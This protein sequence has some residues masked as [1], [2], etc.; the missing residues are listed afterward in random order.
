MT[1]KQTATEE[2]CSQLLHT[3]LFYTA[4]PFAQGMVM[5]SPES[6]RNQ[7]NPSQ[8]C[9]QTTLIEAV[10]QLTLNYRL[11]PFEVNSN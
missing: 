1:S 5:S 7:D 2:G 11:C 8:T 3:R 9:P 4:E 6:T 10:T